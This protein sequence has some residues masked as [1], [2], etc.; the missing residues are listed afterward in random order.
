VSGYGSATLA[1]PL[2]ASTPRPIAVVLHGEDDRPDWQCGSFRGLL[3]GGI[4]ILC[5]RG[6]PSARSA[7]FTWGPVEAAGAEL[8]AALAALKERYS[9][10]V[11]AGPILLIGFGRGGEV[12]AQLARQ[13]PSFFARVA[14]IDSDAYALSSSAAAI[15]S[16]R[17][18]RRVLF[19]CTSASCDDK[20]A[21]R[22]LLLS[23][24]NVP[25]RAVRK[26]VGPYLDAAYTA[27]L[28]PELR[29]LLEGD[30]RFGGARPAAKRAA[31]PPT[32]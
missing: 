1:L 13:E 7:R 31:S 30:A 16:Q 12:A 14:L 32:P 21:T 24:A 11:A 29:W 15:F 17:G 2:G 26:P 20:A 25:T 28:A 4:F 5:P 27:A 18:G 8:R 23:R 9:G 19:F 10:H 22:A 6:A 3:G